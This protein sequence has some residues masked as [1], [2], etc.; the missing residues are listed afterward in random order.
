MQER[1]TDSPPDSTGS[2]A[3]G[4]EQGS[5]NEREPERQEKGRLGTASVVADPDR[6]DEC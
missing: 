3:G 2:G 6:P 5:K 1:K 4:S